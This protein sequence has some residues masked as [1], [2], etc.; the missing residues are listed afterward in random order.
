MNYY[1]VLYV[2]MLPR[3]A[4]AWTRSLSV[5]AGLGGLF[6]LLNDSLIQ[7]HNS[8]VSSRKHT[9]I[10]RQRVWVENSRE[11]LRYAGSVFSQRSA[12]QCADSERAQHL[13][14]R[15]LSCCLAEVTLSQWSLL[16]CRKLYPIHH[17]VHYLKSLGQFCSHVRKHSGKKKRSG[18]WNYTIHCLELIA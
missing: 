3:T 13:T 6:G 12:A 15:N 17:I 9:Y 8:A 5:K 7:I 1:L 18:L 11:T 10:M 4:R 2:A 16:A 14:H